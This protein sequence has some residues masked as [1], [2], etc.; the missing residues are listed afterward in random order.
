MKRI[1]ISAGEASGD[2][3]AAAV[4]RAL[5]AQWPDAEIAGIAGPLMRE[6]GCT[7]WISMDRLNVMGLSDVVRALP[8]IRRVRREVLHRCAGW[9]P[10]LAILVDFSSFHARLGRDLRA[11]GVPVL[12]YIAP[13]LWAWG[14]WRIRSLAA[15]QDALACILPFEPAWFGA[16]GIEAGYVGNPSVQDCATGWERCAFLEHG[17]LSGDAPVL[18][19]LPGSRPQELREHV[20]L[21]AAM[22]DE[23]GDGEAEVI[24][25]VA[26]GVDRDALQP[27]IRRGA[28]LIDRN[29]PGFALRADAALAVSGTAT[30]ELALWDVPTVLVYRT[31]PLTA[32]LG[33]RLLNTRCIGLANII[34]DDTRVMPELWQEEATPA[35]MLAAVRPLLA[36]GPAAARQRQGFAELRRRLGSTD[37]AAGVARMAARLT[38]KGRNP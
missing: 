16:R 13:K 36:G 34:L 7:A 18:A 2:R 29:Q 12:R 5:R 11:L 30:L 1:F 3:H 10:D 37:P 6:A 28:H 27:L 15:S 17:G 31:T 33:R 14:S 19:L 24:V 32:W 38:L 35:R 20:P 9:R 22:L 26:P 8:R 23:L 4:V 25:P 21:F